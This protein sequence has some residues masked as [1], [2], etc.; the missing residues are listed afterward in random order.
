M[1]VGALRT[2]V[3]IERVCYLS[4]AASHR[5]GVLLTGVLRG[6]ARGCVTC[7]PQRRIEPASDTSNTAP[8]R[9]LRGRGLRGRG[10]RGSVD[11]C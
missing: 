2:C 10:L 4:P 11:G 6:Y 5:E 8:E 9:G 1:S 7:P 3:G